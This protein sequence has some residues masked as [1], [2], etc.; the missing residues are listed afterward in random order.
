MFGLN[1]YPNGLL[2]RPA[3]APSRYGRPQTRPA[4]RWGI[5]WHR[6]LN[7][8]ERLHNAGDETRKLQWCVG[9]GQADTVLSLRC[10]R[11]VLEVLV[12]F[13][14]IAAPVM[15]GCVRKGARKNK[16]QL[17]PAVGMLGNRPARGDAEKTRRRTLI[18]CRDRQLIRPQA[19]TLPVKTVRIGAYVTPQRLRQDRLGTVAGPG[20]R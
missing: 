2:V 5:A 20:R 11:S 16:R 3:A 8:Q 6:A 14:K 17:E 15:A 9:H 19:Q 1:V 18:P 10:K 12:G 4:I 7:A 13:L